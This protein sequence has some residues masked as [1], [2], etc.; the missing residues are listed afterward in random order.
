MCDDNFLFNGIS[1]RAGVAGLDKL[2]EHTG[3]GYHII[4]AVEVMAQV[5]DIILG[6]VETARSQMADA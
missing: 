1:V 4:A 6:R 5:V 3:V 2:A